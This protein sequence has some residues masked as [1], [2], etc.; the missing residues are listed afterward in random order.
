MDRFK[1]TLILAV[2]AGL[3]LAGTTGVAWAQEER[4]RKTKETV[5][6]S[7]A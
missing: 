3:F 2:V 1:N 4:E 5:A 6:M 7:Q